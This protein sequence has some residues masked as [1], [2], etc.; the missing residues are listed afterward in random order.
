MALTLWLSSRE[1]WGS[2]RGHA[3]ATILLGSD[4][5]KVV[6]SQCLLSLLRRNWG[7]KGITETI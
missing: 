6:H 2:H 4:R 3:S 1:V 5:V 7:T